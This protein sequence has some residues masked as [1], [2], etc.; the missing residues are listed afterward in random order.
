MAFYET[1]ITHKEDVGED[2]LKKVRDLICKIKPHSIFMA[3]DLADPH[4][5]HRKCT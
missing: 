5:T 1:G 2:D 3:G 4:G